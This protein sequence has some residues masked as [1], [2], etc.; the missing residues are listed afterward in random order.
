LVRAHRGE[1]YRTWR[2]EAAL[3][4]ARRE[5]PEPEPKQKPK[6]T[7]RVP[8]SRGDLY[9]G[10]DGKVYKREHGSWYRN[11][12]DKWIHLSRKPRLAKDEEKRKARQARLE[13][14]YDARRRAKEYRR[15]SRRRGRRGMAYYARRGWGYRGGVRAVTLARVG[16]GGAWGGMRW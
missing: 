6:P 11:D 12:N 14:S 1:A 16:G 3:P 2:G 8:K 7:V 13:S 5:M 10:A 15:Y 4:A 9:A